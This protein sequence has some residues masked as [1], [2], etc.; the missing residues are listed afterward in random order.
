MAGKEKTQYVDSQNKITLHPKY[1]RK[2]QQS[3]KV[4]GILICERSWSRVGGRRGCR[5]RTTSVQSA[6][7]QQG[8]EDS[9]APG[10]EL[11]DPNVEKGL[12]NSTASLRDDPNRR[13]G[14][15]NTASLRAVAEH[16]REHSQK[17]R[18]GRKHTVGVLAR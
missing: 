15:Q 6:R 5:W 3:T 1:H 7:R 2:S 18:C 9:T 11:E 14:P 10:V 8:L 12:S 4:Y 16:S 13:T 17:A